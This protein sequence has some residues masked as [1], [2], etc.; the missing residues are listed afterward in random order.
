MPWRRQE[1]H[2]TID[3]HMCEES[4]QTLYIYQ[5]IL[6]LEQWYDVRAIIIPIIHV[7]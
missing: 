5:L 6:S 7:S 3:I 1:Y 2:Y 4:F